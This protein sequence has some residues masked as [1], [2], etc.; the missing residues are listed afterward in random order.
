MSVPRNQRTPKAKVA[1]QDR[2]IK[3][4]GDPDSFERE[5]IA[6]QFFRQDAEHTDWG[7]NKLRPSDWRDIL[8]RLKAFEGLT[9]A[10]LNAQAGGRRRGTN[11]HPCPITEFCRDA[12]RR[13]TELHLD[14]FDSLFS[15]RINNTLRI[16]GVRD[17]RVLQL[18]WHDPHH[19]SGRG[20]YPTVTR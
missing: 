15:L 20:A 13:L 17:G 8:A 16:Y 1:V 4:G 7:W 2:Q 11:H 12:R 9:W 6:W 5:T 18:L 10:A 3:T 19:G 14:E